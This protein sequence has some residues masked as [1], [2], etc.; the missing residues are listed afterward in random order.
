[1]AHP[2][3]FSTASIVRLKTE[4]LLMDGFSNGWKFVVWIFQS[5]EN[6]F[7]QP[8]STAKKTQSGSAGPV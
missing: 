7:F 3:A 5:L 8:E 2:A 1:M 4:G 6:R